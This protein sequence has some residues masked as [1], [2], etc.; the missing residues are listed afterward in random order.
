[1][2]DIDASVGGVK[3]VFRP[4]DKEPPEHLSRWTLY[5]VYVEDE[6]MGLATDTGERPTGRSE[7]RFWRALEG[8]A[9]QVGEA[10]S[11]DELAGAFVRW[12]HGVG[13]GSRE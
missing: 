11:Q 1:V 6:H 4:S 9:Y 5:D 12:Y 13:G 3:V 10:L 2:E 7:E 8:D